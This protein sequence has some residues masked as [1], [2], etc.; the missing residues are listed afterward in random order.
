MEGS[1]QAI[2]GRVAPRTGRRIKL[3]GD[4]PGD[5]RDSERRSRTFKTKK[6]VAQWLANAEAAAHA[7]SYVDPR[8]GEK[9]FGVVAAEWL[10]DK[11]HDASRARTATTTA[12]SAAG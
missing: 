7:G 9:L 5:G 6:A 1:C 11:E 8:K 4:P 2:L 12:R 3:S 10:A